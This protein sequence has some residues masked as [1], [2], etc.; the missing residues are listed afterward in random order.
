MEI[1]TRGQRLVTRHLRTVSLCASGPNIGLRYSW[2]L[3]KYAQLTF[4]NKNRGLTVQ[5]TILFK[6]LLLAAIKEFRNLLA[7]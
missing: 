1:A 6:L 3:V 5:A 2:S 7:K 4:R